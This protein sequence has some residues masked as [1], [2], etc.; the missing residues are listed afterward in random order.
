MA[1]KKV[2]PTNNQ[3]IKEIIRRNGLPR[4]DEAGKKINRKL[5]KQITKRLNEEEYFYD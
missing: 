3:R 2:A 4:R 5:L 1:K